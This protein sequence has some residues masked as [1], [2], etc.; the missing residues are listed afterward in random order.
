MTDEVDA[1]KQ[2]KTNKKHVFAW[3]CDSKMFTNKVKLNV[4]SYSYSVK[5][6]LL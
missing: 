3:K 5:A 1:V 4:K 2:N 6:D